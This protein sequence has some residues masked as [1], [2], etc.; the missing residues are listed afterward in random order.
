[1]L[2]I[3]MLEDFRNNGIEIPY[4]HRTIVYK[5]HLN[6]IMENVIPADSAEPMP[7]DIL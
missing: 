2:N 7:K 3:N 5:N 4:P 1:M 6:D